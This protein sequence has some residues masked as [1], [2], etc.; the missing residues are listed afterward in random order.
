MISEPEPTDVMPTMR[1]PAMPIRTVA[2]RFV[3]I[4]GV[5]ETLRRA[6][7]GAAVRSAWTNIDVAA[8]S[9]AQPSRP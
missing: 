1:P 4:G 6:P 9:R 3:L 2:V 5:G 8:T 7:G